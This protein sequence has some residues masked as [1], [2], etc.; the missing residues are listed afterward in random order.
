[1]YKAVSRREARLRRHLRVR[2]RV[3][4]T[5]ERP[6][7]VVFRSH[8]HI[9]AQV[10]DDTRGHTIAAA[11]T[12]E[13]GVREQLAGKTKTEQ[14]RIVGELV[15]K[16][17]KERGVSRVVFDRGGYQYHGRVMAVAEGARAGKLEF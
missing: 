5:P 14:A 9:Y 17:A 1:M 6:R 4:G 3:V 10:V 15:A 7:L 13:P 12:V 16:R 2:K 8:E 11:S